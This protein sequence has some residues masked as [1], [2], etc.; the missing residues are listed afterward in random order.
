MNRNRSAGW[1]TLVLAVAIL[2]VA[3]CEQPAAAP[4]A[5]TPTPAPDYGITEIR[6][7]LKNGQSVTC[8]LWNPNSGYDSGISC[9]WG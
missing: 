4:P 9:N 6:Y 2:L 7:E 3:A 8:L 1:R 5:S